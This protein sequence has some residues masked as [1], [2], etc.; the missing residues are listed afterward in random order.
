MSIP[1]LPELPSMRIIYFTSLDS[2]AANGIIQMLES[3]GQQI[4]LVVATPGPPARRTSAYKDLV[5]NI[6]PGI[7]VLVTSHIKR[8]AKLLRGLEPDLIFVAGFPWRLPPDL[9]ALPRLGSINT[10]PALLPGY[11]GPDPF[12]WQMM[13]GETETGLTTHRIEPEFDT[14]PILAQVRVPILPDDDFASIQARF[15]PLAPGLFAQALAA[16]AAG[17]PG[18]P[19]PLEGASYA[20]LRT[21]A[22]RVLDWTR[23]AAHLRNQVRAWGAEGA[24]ATL[25]GRQWVVKQARVRD[26]ASAGR[27]SA[28]PGQV[29]ARDADGLLVQTGDGLL[30]LGDITPDEE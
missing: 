29:V 2:Q 8:L 14:G 28:A 4:L 17:E 16:V 27:P 30:H 9:I 15:F 11:R 23:P 6:Q 19:Q 22:D 24:L 7:D 13:N 25:D 10:H 26:T 12:F 5:A 1:E 18:R 20:P 21:P 3:F